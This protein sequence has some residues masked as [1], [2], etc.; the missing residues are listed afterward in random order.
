MALEHPWDVILTDLKMPALDGQGLYEQVCRARPEMAHR[1]IFSTGD[2]VNPETLAFLR[3]T[4][5]AYLSKPFKLESVLDLV[6]R[7][8]Q[9]RA[10]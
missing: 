4:G 6:S 5:C 9:P 1:F 2:L 3:T 8:A 7:T 10:A